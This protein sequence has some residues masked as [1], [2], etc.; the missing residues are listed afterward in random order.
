M[1]PLA[2]PRIE[3]DERKNLTNGDMTVS[4]TTCFDS[5]SLFSAEM[6][7]DRTILI[8]LSLMFAAACLAFPT[9]AARIK[10]SLINTA[11]LGSALTTPN[12]HSHP[13]GEGLGGGSQSDPIMNVETDPIINV[14]TKPH[15]YK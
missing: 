15:P 9:Y 5:R 10:S 1:L 2:G 7:Q 3:V 8:V 14:E 11:I 12:L 4:N 13:Q 6:S